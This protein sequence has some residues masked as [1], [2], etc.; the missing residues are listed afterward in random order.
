MILVDQALTK[1]EG[2]DVEMARVVKLRYFAGLEIEEVAAALGSS[3]RSVNRLWTAA[4][5][6]LQAPN[7]HL[8]GVPAERI[9]SVEG[10]VDVV[11]YLDAM[12][13]RL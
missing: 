5:A 9:A 4:R 6:W 13:G 10:L 1:L 2:L 8:N 3:P 7:S 12:R 11:Q